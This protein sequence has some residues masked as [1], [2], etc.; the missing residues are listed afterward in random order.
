MN[1]DWTF[2]GCDSDDQR[3]IEQLWQD[4]QSELESKIAE[5]SL[6]P[7][8]L[9]LAIA[10]DSET[11]GWELQAALH[12]T[13]RT[14]ATEVAG[15]SLPMVFEQAVADLVRA[16]NEEGDRPIEISRRLQ[17]LE[18]IL[19]LLASNRREGRSFQFFT[20]LRPLMQTLRTHAQRE[21]ELL[22]LE[23]AVA[24]DELEVD[25]VLDEALLR[26]WDQFEWRPADVPLDLWLI[27][28]VD[29]VLNDVAKGVPHESLQTEREVALPEQDEQTSF[30]TWLEQAT[31][32][33]A[34]ELGDLLPG[35]PGV[36]FWDR[37]DFE[38]KQTKL[39]E[40]LS[41][42]SRDHRQL[43]VLH[44]V[45]GFEPETIAALQGRSVQ[46]V[47]AELQASRERLSEALENI[48]HKPA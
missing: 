27:S 2:D 15:N 1:V 19:P 14:L 4:Y 32:P 35:V 30:A 16:V 46:E 38:A 39:A 42:L 20:F 40:L 44:A 13:V 29:G 45:E 41:Y 6:E 25:D 47:A 7:L 8:E 24:A 21:L 23:G 31:Y 3:A 9:R 12:L 5:L 17:G 36:D 48:E 37:L 26:A 11:D 28:L 22:E 10:H 34:V 18:A 43:L 33:E